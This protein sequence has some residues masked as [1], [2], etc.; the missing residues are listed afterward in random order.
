LAHFYRL[1]RAH[2]QFWA[3]L[4][5]ESV[6]TVRYEGYVS[7]PEAQARKLLTQMGMEWDAACASPDRRQ[8]FV[9]T[10]S[11]AQVKAPVHKK[12][13]HRWKHY[14]HR[15][16]PLIHHLGGLARIEDMHAG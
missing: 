14:E 5:P 10:S 9:A 16:Q 4:A 12:A 15:L 3:E 7:E 1:Y 2:M 11:A 8:Q 6:L 13:I